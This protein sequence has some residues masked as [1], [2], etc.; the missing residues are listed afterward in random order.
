MY[1]IAKL[2][3][4]FWKW[5]YCSFFQDL[6]FHLPIVDRYKRYKARTRKDN[7]GYIFI[8]YT[9][10][11]QWRLSSARE[12]G[13]GGA[14]ERFFSKFLCLIQQNKPAVDV[15]STN[16]HC[17]KIRNDRKQTINDQ[18]TAKKMIIFKFHMLS[19]WFKK[20]RKMQEGWKKVSR[21]LHNSEKE[22]YIVELTDGISRW[23]EKKSSLI[24]HYHNRI[25]DRLRGTYA[26]VYVHM[27]VWPVIQIARRAT[28]SLN[29]S[30]AMTW[31]VSASR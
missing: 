24:Y 8:L 4:F 27:Y 28:S 20:K 12:V 21:G 19:P 26:C 25:R 7:L 17:K 5:K 18:N 2:W 1:A 10:I 3:C 16:M 11:S 13:E 15:P 22:F 23:V 14:L 29:H 9:A 30:L 31:C 6:H